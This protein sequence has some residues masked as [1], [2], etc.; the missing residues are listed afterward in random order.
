[1]I[2][3]ATHTSNRGGASPVK[4]RMGF[5]WT[6]GV[7]LGLAVGMGGC[8]STAV[9]SVTTGSSPTQP[10]PDPEILYRTHSLPQATVYSL[11]IPV[12]GFQVVPALATG[13]D[14][15]D[16]F[17]RQQGAIA[18]INAGF[19][20]PIN[21]KTTSPV[22]LHGKLAADPRL[23]DRLM[24]NPALRPYLDRILN[25]SEFRRY[26][27]QGTLQYAIARHRDSVPANCQ[28]MDAVGG[29]PQLLPDNTAV[30]EG[31]VDS[32]DGVVVRDGIGSS[33]PNARSAVGITADGSILLVMVAQ[34]SG[35]PAPSGMSLADL[36]GFMQ[37]LGAQQAMNL[38]GGTSSALYF[39]GKTLYGKLDDAENPVARPVKSV[40]L[41]QKSPQ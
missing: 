28:L 37:T 40:L 20:D 24:T 9:P 21:Q 29:G 41:V 10:M 15:V 5:K 18:V 34:K 32:V 35:V 12:H 33:Q 2:E 3:R 27:C 36:A 39:Q 19:F 25:R 30:Q 22:T 6:G 16:T 23:N 7:L 13:V 8:H 31:F 4:F 11:Q 1:M 17:A 38:D 14:E 26:R